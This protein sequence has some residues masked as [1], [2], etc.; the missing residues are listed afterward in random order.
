MK[1]VF[2]WC[3]IIF[4]ACSMAGTFLSERIWTI[5]NYGVR[6][7]EIPSWYRLLEICLLPYA[8]LCVFLFLFVVPLWIVLL[9]LSLRCCKRIWHQDTKAARFQLTLALI[10]LCNIVAAC[11][12]MSQA[13]LSV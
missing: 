5:M 4:S 9:I 8:L 12:L 1:K 11:W 6:G 7:V 2:G 3:Y 10:H 13:L